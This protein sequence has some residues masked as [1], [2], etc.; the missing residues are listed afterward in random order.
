MMNMRPGGPDLPRGGAGNL[1][2]LDLISLEVEEVKP[3]KLGPDIPRGG[4]GNLASSGLTF[5]E[6]E[7]ELAS[8]RLA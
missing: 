3:V 4:A 2:S 7:Q 1:A 6:L 5:L 8:S